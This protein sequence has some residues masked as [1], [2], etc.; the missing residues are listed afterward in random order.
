MCNDYANHVPYSAYLAAFSQLKVRL[1]AVGGPPNLEPRDD[2]WPTDV[3]AVIRANEDGAELVQLRWDFRP[4]GRKVRPSS[5]CAQRAGAL[6][7]DDV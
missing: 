5:T 6:P 1:F 7:A 4:T 2:I 3:G